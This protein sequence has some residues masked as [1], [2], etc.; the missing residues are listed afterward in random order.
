VHQKLS[1]Q[2][3]ND[4]RNESGDLEPIANKESGTR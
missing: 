1:F 4:K 3:V 2:V